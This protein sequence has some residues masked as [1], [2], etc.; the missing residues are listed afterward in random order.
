MTVKREELQEF[1]AAALAAGESRGRIGEVLEQAGWPPKQ[2]QAALDSYADIAFPVPVPRPVISPSARESFLYLLLFTTLYMTT[3]GLGTILYQLINLALPDKLAGEYAATSALESLRWGVSMLIVFL[4]C[5]LLLDRMIERL[6][7]TDPTH[8]RSRVRRTLTYL[9]LYVAA[10]I[11]LMDVG[12]L[13]YVLLNGELVARI[14]LKGLVLGGL[15]GVILW[16][17]LHEMRADE[18]MK[19]AAQ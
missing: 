5:Y 19:G 9:T 16:R 1:V 18:A 4:P 7:L 6:K 17:Y 10:T 13:L 12:Y 11:M 2:V 14:L 15:A 8:G 3:S